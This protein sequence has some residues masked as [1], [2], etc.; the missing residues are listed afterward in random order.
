MWACT[1]QG[2]FLGEDENNDIETLPVIPI[3]SKKWIPVLFYDQIHCL[4]E[5]GADVN[6][7]DNNG[8]AALDYFRFTMKENSKNEDPAAL[9]LYQSLEYQESCQAIEELLQ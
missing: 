5:N 1:Y 7:L 8:Y 6:A 3:Q 2:Y 4:V 9:K